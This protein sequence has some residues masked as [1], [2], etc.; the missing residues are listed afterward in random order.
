MI[1]RCRLRSNTASN[2]AQ[3]ARADFPVPARPPREM[4]PTWLSKSRSMAIRCSAE[5]PCRPKRSRSPRTRLIV[6][7]EVTR[8][9][10]EPR[11]LVI[12]TPV[13]SGMPSMSS[14]VSDSVSYRVWTSVEPREISA[15]PV[16][17]E[18]T[19][20]SARYSSAARPTEAAFTRIGRSFE[21][22]VTAR[23]SAA[24]FTAT[25]KMRE[26]LSPTCKPLGRT[27]WLG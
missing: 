6:F 27:D 13:L 1:L 20:N 19:A 26:S 17:P 8:P 15:I 23:P 9:R 16:H 21:T 18:S 22:T 7:G 10:A 24:R 2:P 12:T 4:I 5:R 14:V 3:R 25:A 11:S